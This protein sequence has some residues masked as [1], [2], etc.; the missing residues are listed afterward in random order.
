ML[1]LFLSRL[2]QSF[3]SNARDG[4]MTRQFYKCTLRCQILF[5]FSRSLSVRWG[6]NSS[7]T[8]TCPKAYYYHGLIMDTFILRCLRVPHPWHPTVTTQIP[9]TL[10][11][12]YISKFFNS[13]VS[14]ITRILLSLTREQFFEMVP[15]VL[16]YSSTVIPLTIDVAVKII[17]EN[18]R[19]QILENKN[20]MA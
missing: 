8:H 20:C 4:Q 1:Y 11:S 13:Q 14:L 19:K 16:G 18:K 5:F 17:I 3:G 9:W 10:C 6:D 2:W 7:R 12:A 15:V